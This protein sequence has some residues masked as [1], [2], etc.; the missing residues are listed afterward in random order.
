MTE[1]G[2]GPGGHARA[3]MCSKKKGTQRNR[4][5]AL[6]QEQ[7]VNCSLCGTRI[8]GDL[9]LVWQWPLVEGLD[10]GVRVIDTVSGLIAVLLEKTEGIALSFYDQ[11]GGVE[12]AAQLFR[13]CE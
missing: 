9:Q 11:G 5:V 10:N 12:R 4:V 2:V 1:N 13:L 7:K 8:F 6:C 3:D